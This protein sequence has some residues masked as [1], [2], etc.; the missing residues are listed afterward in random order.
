MLRELFPEVSIGFRDFAGRV[1]L[2]MQEGGLELPP[3]N[4]PDGL[5]KVLAI[6]TA[7]ELK[8]P[9]YLLMKLRIV[10]TPGPWR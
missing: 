4:M 10:C 8:P 7:V 5:I 1:A 9:F 2:I 3:P 6:A